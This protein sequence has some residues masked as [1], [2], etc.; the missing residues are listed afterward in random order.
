MVQPMSLTIKPLRPR[1]W[2]DLE[3][4]FIEPKSGTMPAP[5]VY[6]GPGSAFRAA[7]FTEAA[8]RSETQPIFRY[9]IGDAR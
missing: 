5:F 3:K 6:T 7:V 4:L 8:R 1:R 9:V 2:G